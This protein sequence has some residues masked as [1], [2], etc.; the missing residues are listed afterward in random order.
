[1]RAWQAVIAVL[2]TVLVACG[3]TED[4]DKAPGGGPV[5]R[6]DFN[7]KVIEA[8]CERSARCGRIEDPERCQQQTALGAGVGVFIRLNT[9]YDE[10]LAAGRIRYDAQVAGQC[11]QAIREGSCE[12]NPLS[13]PM[14]DRGMEYDPRCRFLQGQVADGAACEWSTECQDGA[15]CDATASSCGGVCRRGTVAEPADAFDACPPGTVLRG[16]K[17]CLTPGGE[18]AP[19]GSGAGGLSGICGQGLWCDSTQGTCRRVSKEGEACDEPEGPLCGWSLFCRE[20]RCEKPRGP[21]ASCKSP[22]FVSGS[23]FRECR[24]DL[25]C[26]GD[27]NGQPGICRPLLLA[28]ASCRHAFECE[29]GLNCIG[30]NLQQGVLGTCQPAPRQGEA[31]DALPCASHL[32]CTINS[33]TPTCV[34]LVRMGEPCSDTDSCYLVSGWCVDGICQPQGAQSC[35]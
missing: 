14:R 13:R 20:G 25:F 35:P 23:Y 27:A 22:D 24:G 16:N 9:R 34:P 7:A 12:E 11:V 4:S 33:N 19:C 21:G 30:A 17:Q 5:E 26:D 3:G 2:L 8:Y 32:Q 29:G 15:Y 31:C 6:A 28:N 1:M 18:G 10:A